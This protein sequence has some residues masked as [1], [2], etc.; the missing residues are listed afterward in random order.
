MLVLDTKNRTQLRRFLFF[1]CNIGLQTSI[2]FVY[3]SYNAIFLTLKGPAQLAFVLILPV[4]KFGFKYLIAK[5]QSANDDLVPAILSSVDIF[6]ALYMT[7][8]MQS[9]G[10]IMVGLGIIAIDLAH[11]THAMVGL[12][13]QTHEL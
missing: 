10:T 13:R 7:K 3:P 5:V 1:T 9:A 4:I 11:N 2:M 8:C 6:D 12:A